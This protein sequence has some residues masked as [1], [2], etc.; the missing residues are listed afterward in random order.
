MSGYRRLTQDDRSQI[1]ALHKRG[2]SQQDI[3]RHLGVSQS[4]ISREL[5]RNR[6][7]RRCYGHQRR[8]A[9]GHAQ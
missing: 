2:V 5:R 8:H 6:G 9:S 4:T 7:K 1:Y 3:G